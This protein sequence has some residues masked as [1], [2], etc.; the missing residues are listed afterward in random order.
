MGLGGLAPLCHHA[1]MGPKYFLVC[2][3]WYDE[4]SEVPLLK[5]MDE[6]DQPYKQAKSKM[7]VTGNIS[8][9]KED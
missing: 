8:S 4:R 9:N 6:F 3:P 7:Q 2:I 1:F 5:S